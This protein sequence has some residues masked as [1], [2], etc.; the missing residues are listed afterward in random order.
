MKI[1]RVIQCIVPDDT[2]RLMTIEEATARL[3]TSRA[4]LNKLFNKREIIPI[5]K[6]SCTFV[7]K[8]ELN[9]F[10]SKIQ[11]S[12]VDLMELMS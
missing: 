9:R 1:D 5:K 2:D 6:G 11:S 4:G 8:S 3:Q 7:S 10:I 12:G